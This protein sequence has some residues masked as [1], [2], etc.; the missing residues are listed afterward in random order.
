MSGERQRSGRKMIQNRERSASERV[1]E[2][3]S[4]GEMG[5]LRQREVR[6]RGDQDN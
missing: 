1:R 2:R 4:Q 5:S 3:G 6:E